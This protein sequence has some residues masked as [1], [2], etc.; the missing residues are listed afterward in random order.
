KRQGMTLVVPQ[1]GQIDSGFSRCGIL[2]NGKTAGA[3]ALF[4]LWA[5]SARLKSCPD[6]SGLLIQFFCSLSS[7]ALTLIRN[8]KRILLEVQRPS[9]LRLQDQMHE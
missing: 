3:K 2:T 9:F 7:R 8:R 4:I 5:L 6:A 1:I